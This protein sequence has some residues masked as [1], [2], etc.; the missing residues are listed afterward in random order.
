MPIAPDTQRAFLDAEYRV[1]LPQ[2][3]WAVIRIGESLPGALRSLSRDKREPWG[4]IT[5]WNPCTRQTSRERNRAAQRELLALLRERGA[6]LRAGA[7]VGKSGWREPSLFAIGLP[8]DTLDELGRRFEQAAI[9][10][11]IGCGIARL[12]ELD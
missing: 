6:R 4:F 3:G 7:G 10:R 2:G 9:V 11:G 12:R 1:R 8:F 5:A